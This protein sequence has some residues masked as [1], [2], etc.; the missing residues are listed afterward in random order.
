LLNWLVS[1][2]LIIFII[3]IFGIF[4]LL[5]GDR[6]KESGDLLEAT[7]AMD[8]AKNAEVDNEDDDWLHSS[9]LVTISHF[10][11]LINWLLDC[12]SLT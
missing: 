5:E 3:L 9:F 11:F 2:V 7:K 12:S 1:Q 8:S 6:L 10:S 4:S